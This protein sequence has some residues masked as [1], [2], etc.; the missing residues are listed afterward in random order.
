MS[1]RAS[2]WRRGGSERRDVPHRRDGGG[3]FSAGLQTEAAQS[4]SVYLSA[5]RLKSVCVDELRRLQGRAGEPG[6]EDE[7]VEGSSS[8]GDLYGHQEVSFKASL[9]NLFF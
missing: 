5:P 1:L 8:L 6:G 9:W 7:Y 3:G 4:V 2:R